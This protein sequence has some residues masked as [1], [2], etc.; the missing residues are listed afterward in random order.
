MLGYQEWICV[1][2][3]ALAGTGCVI[4]IYCIVSRPFGK[5]AGLISALALAVTPIFVAISRNETMD[6]QMV[7]VILLAVWVVLKAA[8]EQSLPYLLAAAA[9]AGLAFNIK[10]IQAFIIV[11][12][13][14]G[15]YLW[16]AT[17][18]TW[19]KRIL[20]LALAA[21]LL[22]AVSFSWALVVDA[23]PADQ[24]PYIGGSGDNTVLGLVINY[25]GIHRL[26]IGGGGM[27]GG[28]GGG[29]GGSFGG[30]DAGMSRSDRTN[31]SAEAP[32]PDASSFTGPGDSAGSNAGAPPGTSGSSGSPA[33]TGGPSGMGRMNSTTVSP[34]QSPASFAGPGGSAA[35][36]GSMSGTPPGMPGSSQDGTS[37]TGQELRQASFGMQQSSSGI[38]SLFSVSGKGA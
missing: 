22:L 20:H 13:I 35:G 32:G 11:P 2:P 21:I 1:L 18:L 33:A 23:I 31:N 30:S 26:G 6:T 4:L 27:G 10:M 28:M 34:G 12:A 29:P 14:F 7:F 16:G 9:L 38:L 37:G 24:R 5:P 17:G 25:N 19:K 15:I 3:E 36:A 8:R